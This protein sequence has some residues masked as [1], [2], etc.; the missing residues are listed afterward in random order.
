MR[1]ARTFT[2]RI[3]ATLE[4]KYLIIFENN[5]S[6]IWRDHT[7]LYDGNALGGDKYLDNDIKEAKKIAEK[8]GLSFE[9]IKEEE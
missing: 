4:Q 3:G 7:L 8:F 6:Q 5:H 1:Q 9:I 2:T